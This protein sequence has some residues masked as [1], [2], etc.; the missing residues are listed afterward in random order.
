V[1]RGGKVLKR[2]D[3]RVGLGSKERRGFCFGYLNS[4]PP[5]PPRKAREPV[6]SVRKPDGRQFSSASPTVTRLGLSLSE[7]KVP[8]T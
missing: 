7:A 8:R 5:P 3:R 1:Q 2:S 6:L 4:P